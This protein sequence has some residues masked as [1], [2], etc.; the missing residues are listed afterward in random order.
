MFNREQVEAKLRQE[1]KDQIFNRQLADALA[2]HQTARQAKPQNSYMNAG[3]TSR[4]TQTRPTWGEDTPVFK[5]AGDDKYKTKKW[6][7]MMSDCAFYFD[8]PDLADESKMK[9]T[10][11]TK[12][13]DLFPSVAMKPALQTRKDLMNWACL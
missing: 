12:Y 5:V 6:E 7:A 8:K 11:M 3:E 4:Y 13:D 1:T 2:A 9:R 10:L